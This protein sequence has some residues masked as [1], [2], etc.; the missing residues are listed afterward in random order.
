MQLPDEASSTMPA[1]CAARGRLDHSP[2]YGDEL[3]PPN[4]WRQSRLGTR[5]QQVASDG[6]MTNRRRDCPLDTGSIGT[7]RQA[8]EA[9]QEGLKA[10]PTSDGRHPRPGA[11]GRVTC[12]ASAAAW[13]GP[14]RCPLPPY[15]TAARTGADGPPRLTEGNNVDND[16]LQDAHLLENTC[17]GGAGGALG[18]VVISKSLHNRTA[19]AYASSRNELVVL[20]NTPETIPPTSSGTGPSA[21]S[22]AAGRVQSNEILHSGRVGGWY[23][24]NHGRRPGAAAIVGWTFSLLLGAAA[25]PSGSC[26]SRS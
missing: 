23:S 2:N 4:G 3:P 7:A 15:T 24:V 5:S 16:A 1:S 9:L 22:R 17:P 13:R 20:R 26:P 10:N 21:S 8:L 14:L 19:A 18:A 25:R 11:G 6:T 12:S